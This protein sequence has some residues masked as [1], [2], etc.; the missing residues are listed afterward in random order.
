MTWTLLYSGSITRNMQ[1]PDFGGVTLTRTATVGALS[2]ADKEAVC[3][4]NWAG[5]SWR[6]IEEPA[7]SPRRRPSRPRTG[8]SETP[9]EE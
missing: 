6:A 3:A 4:E 1:L 9:A 7:P 5:C 8:R 2:E